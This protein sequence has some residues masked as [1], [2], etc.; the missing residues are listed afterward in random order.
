MIRDMIKD[1]IIKNYSFFI[2]LIPYGS[3]FT[4]CDS[5]EIYNSIY[6]RANIS[7]NDFLNKYN[8]IE[9]ASEIYSIDESEFIND[10]NILQLK[11]IHRLE[12]LIVNN[13]NPNLE[14]VIYF[15]KHRWS[16]QFI[17]D[18]IHNL[19]MKKIRIQKEFNH[20]PGILFKF[21]RMNET[22]FVFKFLLQ[23]KDNF[24]L[25]LNDFREEDNLFFLVK[26]MIDILEEL[27]QKEYN[28]DE[29]SIVGN[30]F[31]QFV[32]NIQDIHNFL[33][34]L[35]HIKGNE[36]KDYCQSIVDKKNVNT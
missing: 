2:S 33:C 29:L 32:K 3:I 24:S 25:M 14:S 16:N 28:L 23:L 7:L 35:K 20:N 15:L 4:F 6:E 11:L 21:K 18:L 10:L 12:K 8:L 36:G 31:L 22:G 27:R 30:V 5:I 13:K 19:K 26:T 1:M 17:K 9:N 34:T